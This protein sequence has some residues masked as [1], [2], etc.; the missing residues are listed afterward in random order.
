MEPVVIVVPDYLQ[1][2]APR[3]GVRFVR[4]RFL[5]ADRMCVRGIWVTTPIRTAFDLMRWS[6]CVEDGLVVADLMAKRLGVDASQLSRYAR[7]HRRFRGSPI[8]R[9]V[10]PL[11]DPLSRSS[12]ESRLRYLWIVEARLPM[13][14]CNPY[15]VDETGDVFAMPDLLDVSSGLVGEYDGS[16]H[17]DLGQHT[18]DNVREEDIES[19][20]L[21]VVRATSL[22]VGRHRDRTV[23]RLR[24]G[25]RRATSTPP[26]DPTWGW[27]PGRV[28]N[29]PV[30][31]DW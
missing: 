19:H 22:D 6:R 31:E 1:H 7:E 30:S 3:A 11:I 25:Y 28:W 5:E 10:T 17:R 12:G 24:D 13:P 4:S 9:A 8:V 2:V 15:L 14:R 20:G 16:T 29:P 18:E 27:R 26:G 21:V 23:R